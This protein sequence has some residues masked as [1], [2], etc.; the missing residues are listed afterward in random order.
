MRAGGTRGREGTAG[1]GVCVGG[2]C[3]TQTLCGGGGCVWGALAARERRAV[4]TK[5][6]LRRG[7]PGRLKLCTLGGHLW[8]LEVI[9]VP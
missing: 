2:V 4:R 5:L 3:V 7:L 9:G 6:E 1:S 8:R